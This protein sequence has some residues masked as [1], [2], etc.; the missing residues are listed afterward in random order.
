MAAENEG[1]LEL[2]PSSNFEWNPLP[3]AWLPRKPDEGYDI[4]TCPLRDS[5]VTYEHFAKIH[6]WQNFYYCTDPKT[7]ENK[8]CC[9]W[10]T[11]VV[12]QFTK[13]SSWSNWFKGWNLANADK[14]D[15]LTL[16][17]NIMK[18]E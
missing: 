9:S 3:P 10:E 11:G 2:E 17:E 16:T 4:V 14:I 5:K 6:G 18:L 13:G 12:E 1:T 15:T 8:L 7:K